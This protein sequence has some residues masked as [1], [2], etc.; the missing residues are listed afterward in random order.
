MERA[1]LRGSVCQ[2]VGKISSC[3]HEVRQ[4]VHSLICKL[5][6]R[7]SISGTYDYY[8]PS[9]AAGSE[10]DSLES[11]RHPRA[12]SLGS[13]IRDRCLIDSEEPEEIDLRLD[14]V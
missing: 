6:S 13:R 2:N 9:G 4:F 14:R 3:G 11:S 1:L 8:V 10:G 12:L 5:S 7:W